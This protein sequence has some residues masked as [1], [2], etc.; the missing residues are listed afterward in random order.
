MKSNV[1][2]TPRCP[3]ISV[4][5]AVLARA[6]RPVVLVRTGGRAED[7]H[8]PDATG[9]PSSALPRREVVLGL[10]LVDPGDAVVEFAFDAAR[11]RAAVL[12]VVHGW[13][14]PPSYGD[15]DALDTGLDAGPADAG[16]TWAGRCT[17]A[18]EGQV[19]RR[20]G[21]YAERGR[22]R[23]RPPRGRVPGSGA[24]RRGTT[25]PPRTGRQPHRPGHPRGA[26]PRL[27]AGG[28]DPARLITAPGQ[29]R[30]TAA[31]TPARGP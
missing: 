25:D 8:L 20:R 1:W 6:E 13:S 16:T 22:W 18:V 28:G 7:E 17:G 27:R 30:V 14:V 19:P 23:G 5:L 24:G 12:R 10:D 9:T 21:A 29:S 26:P 3:T 4:A 11:R 2:S 15:E 31:T